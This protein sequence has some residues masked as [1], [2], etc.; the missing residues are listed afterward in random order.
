M[1]CAPELPRWMLEWYHGNQNPPDFFVS[2]A[3][4]KRQEG[5]WPDHSHISNTFEFVSVRRIFM[6][7]HIF[8]RVEYLKRFSFS[9]N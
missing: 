3:T 5:R 8:F 7:L 1:E 2:Q 4:S 6:I 9:T